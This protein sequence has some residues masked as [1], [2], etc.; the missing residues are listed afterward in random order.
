VKLAQLGGGLAGSV[1]R[2]HR[3]EGFRLSRFVV[4]PHLAIFP[5]RRRYTATSPALRPL[6][7]ALGPPPDDLRR[8]AVPVA[9][10]GTLSHDHYGTMLARLLIE[11]SVDRSLVR[12]SDAPTRSPL[13]TDRT[14][15]R[16]RTPST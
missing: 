3:R 2:E 15:E 12:W 6:S 8:L 7:L 9:F 5:S 10:L 1:E 13:S 14:T 11:A 16:A 4:E